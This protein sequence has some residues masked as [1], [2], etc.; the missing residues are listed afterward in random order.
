MLKIPLYM[1]NSASEV[2]KMR[3]YRE[4]PNYENYLVSNDGLIKCLKYG[5]EARVGFPK[6]SSDGNGNLRVILD[7]H[8]R[9]VSLLVATA[10]IPNP[11]RSIFVKHIDGD[12]TNNCVENLMW[13]KQDGSEYTETDAVIE[14]PVIQVSYNGTTYGNIKYFC[15]EIGI[16]QKQFWLWLRGKVTV[17]EELKNNEKKGE[18]ILCL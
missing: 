5:Q 3:E 1:L 6:L 4:I 18:I 10:Y 7:Q 12:K 9:S 11:H 15:E 14:P 16:T 8:Y 2:I 13:V 17:P